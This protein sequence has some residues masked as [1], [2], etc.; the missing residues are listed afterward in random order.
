MLP[1]DDLPVHLRDLEVFVCFFLMC[2]QIERVPAHT[3]IVGFLRH[4]LR[5]FRISA[6]RCL[7]LDWSSAMLLLK[8]LL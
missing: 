8:I 6:L 7:I 1:L 2:F 3:L 5:D 4:R